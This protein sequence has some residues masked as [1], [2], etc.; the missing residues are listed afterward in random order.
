MKYS[1][2]KTE[3]ELLKHF[4]KLRIPSIFKTD[5]TDRILFIEDVD[6]SIC[7]LLLKGKVISDSIIYKETIKNCK[8]FYD[9][10]DI[11]EFD[12]YALEYFNLCLQVVEIMKKYYL[13]GK[14]KN[15]KAA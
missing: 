4:Q 11:K 2:E 15:E 5:N 9:D 3:K 7:N 8:K 13:L 1:I 12:D 14:D 6:F 10:T